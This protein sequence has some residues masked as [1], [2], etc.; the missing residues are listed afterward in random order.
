MLKNRKKMIHK[1]KILVLG[2]LVVFSVTSCKDWLYLEPEDAIIVQEYWNSKEEVHAAV[3][4]IY[5][6]MLQDHPERFL[7]W[8]EIRCEMVKSDFYSDYIYVNNGDILPTLSIVRWSP[9]YRT[10]NQCNTVIVK[11]PEVQAKDASFTDKML[12][13][14]LAEA[15]AVRALMYFY[16]A[17][18][19]GEVPIILEPTLDDTKEIRVAKSSQ[20]EVLKQVESDLNYAE[21]RAASTYGDIA[22]DKGRITRAGINAIQSDL[23][24]WMEDYENSIKACNKVINSGKFGL[25]PNDDF[26]FNTLYHQCNSIEGIFELQ[27]TTEYQNPLLFEFEYNRLFY[28]SPDVMEQY[29]PVN[30]YLP[31]DSADI[32]GDRCAYRSSRNYIIWKYIGL[33]RSEAKADDESI[34]NFYIYRYAD[35]LLLKAEALAMRSAE[36]DFE[37]S[38]RLITQIRRRAHAGELTLDIRPDAGLTQRGLIN[39]ILKER[40][41]E[42]MFEGKR[43]TDILRNAKRNHYDRM[44][45]IENVVTTAAPY[46][47]LQTILNKYRDTMSHYFPIPQSDINASYPVLVQNPFYGQ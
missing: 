36:G 26:W 41:R 33:N 3:M 21:S 40:A 18:Y 39:F 5:S 16:L 15:Y 11:A 12:D 7:I 22:N 4:G 13:N 6:S 37:E 2:L 44:D 31:A 10:I 45:L 46:N 38:Y 32:R 23:Y 43:W 24:L 25:V 47:R 1:I 8:G 14:Y 35:I 9:L 42:F 30:I 29:F 34:S 19:Y 17:R 20:I 27:Y 28:A